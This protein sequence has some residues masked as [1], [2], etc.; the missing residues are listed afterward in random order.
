MAINENWK[1]NTLLFAKKYKQD[2]P[3]METINAEID[4]WSNLWLKSCKNTN[5][6]PDDI[7]KTLT[8][9]PILMYPNIFKFFIY[10]L[11]FLS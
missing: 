11:C 5:N 8:C 6:L 9:I 7:E 3:S 1:E 10:L 4:L 2:M